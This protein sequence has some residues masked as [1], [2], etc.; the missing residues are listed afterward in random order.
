MQCLPGSTLPD[1]LRDLGYDA[2]EVGETERI[3]PTAIVERFVAGADGALQPLTTGSTR[4]VAL[5][6]THAGIVKVK[7]YSLSL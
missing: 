6:A 1:S 2:V 5:T 3:L 4:P 7:R